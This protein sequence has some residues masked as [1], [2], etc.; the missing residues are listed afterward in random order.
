MGQMVQRS[1]EQI[2]NNG[3]VRLEP[4]ASHPPA[5]ALNVLVF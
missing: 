4:K 5:I 2:P 1:D 3:A